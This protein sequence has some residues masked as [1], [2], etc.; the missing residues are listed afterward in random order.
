NPVGAFGG[1]N[2]DG[3]SGSENRFVIDGAEAGDVVNGR[4]AT[5]LRIPD[6]H[7]VRY[8]MNLLADFVDEVQVKSSGYAAEYGGATGGV[9]NVITRSGSNRWSGDVGVYYSG[10]R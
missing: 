2:I 7:V 10:D 9:I 8:G 1:I 5:D 6:D 3:S 4:S